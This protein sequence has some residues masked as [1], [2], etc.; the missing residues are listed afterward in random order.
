VIFSAFGGPTDSLASLDRSVRRG[1]AVKPQEGLSDVN[2][3]VLMRAA[4]LA[5]PHY[6]MSYLNEIA[7]TNDYLIT[8]ELAFARG[9]TATVRQSLERLK[10]SRAAFAL[11]EI[12]FDALYP[13]AWLVSQL[14]DKRSAAAWL[15]PALNNIRV[16]ASVTDPINA[17]SLVQT[18]ALRAELAAA[19][20]DNREAER[21]ARAVVTLWSN[22]DP[23]LLPVVDR[24]RQL[25]RS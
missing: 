20:K 8:A 5:F 1:A 4:S 9:D 19:Q 16:Q 12:T 23:F 15:D 25:A 13:E 14:G 10:K 24:M 21:W 2:G 18:M 17:A 6:R 3:V 7:G 22:A 11:P